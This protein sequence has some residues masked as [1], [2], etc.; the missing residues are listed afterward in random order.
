MSVEDIAEIIQRLRDD[1]TGPR[2]RY[3]A[4]I[5]D[6]GGAYER[7]K[8]VTMAAK[9]VGKGSDKKER[10]QRIPLCNTF[11]QS[12]GDG[13]AD[14]KARGWVGSEVYTRVGVVEKT[15]P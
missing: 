12:V 9:D 14:V 7:W 4:E 3:E 15:K 6:D 10:A 1:R 2:C 13:I 11:E 8:S 5:I